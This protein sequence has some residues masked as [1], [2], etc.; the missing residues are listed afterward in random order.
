MQPAGYLGVRVEEELFSVEKAMLAESSEYFRALFDSGMR[1]CSQQEIRVQGL[2]AR[3][4]RILLQV[5]AGERPILAGEEIIDA[6]ECAAFLIAKP[7]SEHMVHTISSSNCVLMF[8][9][10][11]TY[12]LFDLT[13]ASA[14]FMRDLY[15]NVREELRC[16]PKDELS[17]IESFSPSTLVSVATHTPSQGFLDDV[18]RTF[19]YLDEGENVWKTLT[20]LPDKATTSLA[21]VTMMGNNIYI[22]GGVCA[23]NK[24]LVELS[25]CYNTAEDRWNEFPCPQQLRYSLTLTGQDGSLYALGGMYQNVALASV[26]R[27]Q[28]AT[29]TWSSAAHLP[30]PAESV[31]CTRAMGR[32][33]VCLWLPMDTTDIYEYRCAEDTWALVTTLRRPQ[34]YGHCMVAHADN[35]YV[36]RNGPAD[37]FLR[38]AIDC[39]NLTRHQWSALSGQYVNS[40]GAL[41][42]AV[43]RGD[44]VLT[45]NRML[46]LVYDIQNDKWKPAKEKR[47]FPRSG[48]MHT[49]LLRL[50][51]QRP[52]ALH[53]ELPS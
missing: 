43:V 13:Q 5:L 4:F 6:I 30:R 28:V 1:E 12:G 52:A 51:N 18:F 49:F 31:A 41:F 36:M 22:V 19:C 34:S 33:F 9:A 48:S 40:K 20:A 16:L 10:A 46:T 45:V 35:L 17:Y 14:L 23:Y 32:I 25:F 50:P 3:G 42:T 27:Y 29:S 53:P 47:G 21:G 24:R 11:A 7:L 15:P 2:T 39:F 26:E 37:D 44:S 8:Q 38:C